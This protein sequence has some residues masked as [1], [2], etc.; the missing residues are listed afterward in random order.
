MAVIPELEAV[1]VGVGVDFT[2][3]ENVLPQVAN[4]DSILGSSQHQSA[5]QLYAEQPPTFLSGSL[6]SNG[7]M[8]PRA[9]DFVSP[10]NDQL[11]E[12]FA[13]LEG[14]PLNM[15]ADDWAIGEGFDMD[16]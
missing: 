13:S 7:E 14:L 15:E 5:P 11:M 9:N 12:E 16:F 1:S 8:I 2:T 10:G 4:T 6:I 3:P